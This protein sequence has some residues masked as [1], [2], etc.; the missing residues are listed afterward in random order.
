MD[1]HQVDQL[2]AKGMFYSTAE[3]MAISML[4]EVGITL[5]GSDPGKSSFCKRK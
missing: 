3:S 5:N 1:S 2:Q 4:K